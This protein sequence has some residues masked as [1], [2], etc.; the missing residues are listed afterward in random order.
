MNRLIDK[1]GIFIICLMS[2]IMSDNFL[3][4]VIISIVA[5]IISSSAQ[6]LTGTKAAAIIIAAA[7]CTCGVFPL[8]F[9]TIPL[10]L[11]DALWEKKWWLILP[12]LTVLTRISEFKVKQLMLTAAAITVT[13]II[14]MRV[15]HLE[16][17]VRILTALRDEIAGKNLQLSEQNV[18]L[19][20]AQDNEIHLATMRE[21]NRIAREIH[22]NVGHMLTRSLLQSG[23][24]IVINKDEQ[25]R[26]PLQSL[27]NTLDSAMNSIRTSVHDLHDDSIDLAKVIN[28]SISSVDSRFTVDLDCDV[29]ANVPGNIKLCIIGVVK[30]G[31]SNAVKHSSGDHISIVIREHPAFYQLMLKDNGSC[32]EIKES[33]IG[34]K[35]MR[36]RAEA[37]KGMI[38]FTPSKNGFRIFMS[39][40]K[41]DLVS[42]S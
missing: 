23:A 8:M 13:I 12:S 17:T 9:C 16:D 34:L 28:D 42:K 1:I 10:L 27:R 32:S 5:I 7:S 19:A 25:L 41:T 35:N 36:D 39:I 4:P 18:M 24:L 29:S 15:S 2:I 40:P 30:E 37:L 38:T 33:G 22:D 26:E 31:L 20:E 21:R 11:Y 6:L 3:Y 14:Y